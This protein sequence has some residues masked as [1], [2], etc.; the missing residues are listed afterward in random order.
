MPFREVDVV[1]VREVLRAWVGSAGLRTAAARAG[2]DRKT[3]RRYVQAAEAAGLRREA[4]EVGLCDELIGAVIST[5]RPARPGGHGAAWELLEAR[6]AEVSKWVTDGLSVVKIAD[7]LARSGTVVPYRTL[8][9][10]ASEEC[11]F[12]AR[13]TTMRVAEGEPGMECQIDFAQM[14]FIN[15]AVTGRRRKVHALILTA[16]YSRHMFVYLT[17]RQT[18]DD[19]IEGCEAGG[20]RRTV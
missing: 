4:G 19:V 8:H 6:R 10:F 14:G 5:V 1:E 3:A 2:V 12:R 18:L 16:V 7:L 11:G 9:R 15:D 20:V 17:F 13:G